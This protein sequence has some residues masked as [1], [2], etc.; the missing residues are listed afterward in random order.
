M[1]TQQETGNE[2]NS[3]LNDL[4]SVFVLMDCTDYEGCSP[5]HAFRHFEAAKALKAMAEAYDQK[6]PQC[7]TCIDDGNECEAEWAEY[8]RLTAEWKSNHPIKNGFDGADFYS[9]KEVLFSA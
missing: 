1:E 7:P 6:K 8:D 3:A 2:Q 5:L 9:I 4:L